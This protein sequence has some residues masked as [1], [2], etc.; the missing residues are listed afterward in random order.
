MLGSEHPSILVSKRIQ[1]SWLWYDYRNREIVQEDTGL[2]TEGGGR[3]RHTKLPR[4]GKINIGTH[5][6]QTLCIILEANASRKRFLLRI[7]HI[8]VLDQ[9][10]RDQA[11]LEVSLAGNSLNLGIHLVPW[12]L[13]RLEDL[14]E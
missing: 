1:T 10:C 3:R 13:V 8:Q 12:G 9:N 2:G 14:L 6:Q 5:P 4:G 7:T 11:L